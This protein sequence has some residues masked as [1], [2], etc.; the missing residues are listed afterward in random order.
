MISPPVCLIWST[1]SIRIYS[2]FIQLEATRL[3]ALGTVRILLRVF[4][5]MLVC[6]IDRLNEG[7]PSQFGL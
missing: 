7:P 4:V 5:E 6:L 2:A 1:L 3:E